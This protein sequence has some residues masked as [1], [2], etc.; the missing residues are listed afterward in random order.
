MGA[1]HSN[2]DRKNNDQKWPEMRARY[3]GV[4]STVTKTRDTLP[5]KGRG[6]AVPKGSPLSSTHMT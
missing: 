3:P 5:Q 2:G 4:L 6:E 1:I